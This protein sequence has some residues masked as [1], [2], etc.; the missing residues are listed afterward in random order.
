MEMAR[1]ARA[2]HTPTD[3]QMPMQQAIRFLMLLNLKVIK[4]EMKK[5]RIYSAIS[6]NIDKGKDRAIDMLINMPSVPSLHLAIA[7]GEESTAERLIDNRADV[8]EQ[9]RYG[10]TPL[11]IASLKGNTRIVEK[12]K[13]ADVEKATTE[14][15]LCECHLIPINRA[16]FGLNRIHLFVRLKAKLHCMRPFS[17]VSKRIF[18]DS[19]IQFTKNAMQ[20]QAIQMLL[21]SLY[22][23]VLMSIRRISRA[24]HR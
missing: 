5:Q 19:I 6:Y 23:S 20:I 2:T 18:L 14:G 17:E 21:I 10:A 11:F 15:K 16:I 22:G 3:I 8:N 9:T 7:R 24:R 4:C 1:M 12:L 13:W